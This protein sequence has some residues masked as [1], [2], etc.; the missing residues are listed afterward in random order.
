M[1]SAVNLVTSRDPSSI[2]RDGLAMRC[3]EIRAYNDDVSHPSQCPPPL[4]L[5]I[6]LQGSLSVPI[7]ALDHQRYIIDRIPREYRLATHVNGHAI[8][9]GK[10]LMR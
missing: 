6:H 5:G 1:P 3:L 8:L 4:I 9:L 2:Q 10:L 7:S